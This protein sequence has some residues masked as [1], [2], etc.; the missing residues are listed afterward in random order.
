MNNFLTK[1]TEAI[2]LLC[3]VLDDKSTVKPLTVT[4][5]AKLVQ[6]LISVNKRPSD[7]MGQVNLADVLAATGIN[8]ERLDLLLSRGVQLGFAV[9]EWQRNGIWIVSR[10]DNDYPARYKKQLKDKAPPLLFGIGNREL[11][12]GGGLG[13]VGSR[14]IDF[15]GEIFACQ[16][17]EKCALNNIPIVSGGA[18]G[19]DQIAMSSAIENNGFVIGILADNLLRKSLEREVRKA[20]NNQKLLLLSPYNPKASFSVGTAMGRNKLI[21]SISDFTLVVSAEYNKGGTW[22]GA[23]EEL[24]RE[25]GVPV[26]VRFDTD[27]STG[28]K[29]LLALGA[30]KWTDSIDYSDFYNQLSNLASKNIKL[31]FD[32]V[33]SLFDF[34]TEKIA[35]SDDKLNTQ[36]LR[37]GEVKTEYGEKRDFANE[38]YL[39]VLPII[40]Q[41]FSLNKATTIDELSNKLGVNKKQLETWLNLGVA[42]GKIVKLSNPVRYLCS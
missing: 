39:A 24:Q 4:E 32:E 25:N 40:L 38:I 10:S 1:D 13:I 26:F 20:L 23:V 7:L 22:A 9:E 35:Y 14:N 11:L 2:I 28:N 18:R 36:N 27:V 8:Y 15:N 17:A 16:V 6:W 5:Y 30:T 33:P 12:K 42:D 29:K 3:A 34:E 21:Y 41:A 19:V 31:D 37:A